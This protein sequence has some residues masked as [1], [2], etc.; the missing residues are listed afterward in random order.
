MNTSSRTIEHLL[1]RKRNSFKVRDKSILFHMYGKIF[2]LL[3]RVQDNWWAHQPPVT[4]GSDTMAP[5]LDLNLLLSDVNLYYL[6]SQGSK[7]S[8]VD[9]K[10]CSAYVD[11]WMHRPIWIFVECTCSFVWNAV[12]L[13]KYQIPARNKCT[14]CTS[15]WDTV[16]Y[17]ALDITWN[18][19]YCF[20]FYSKCKN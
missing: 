12:S 8:S 17:Y 10:D 3:P 6:G 15:I 5:F 9:S 4:C 11:V 14:E 2:V 20:A 19:V 16:P 1:M 7:G 13:L 18:I